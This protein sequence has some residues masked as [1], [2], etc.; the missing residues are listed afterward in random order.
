MFLQYLIQ[1]IRASCLNF[2]KTIEKY[3]KKQQIIVQL[4]I[5]RTIREYVCVTCMLVSCAVDSLNIQ[6]LILHN[7]NFT[8]FIGPVLWIMKS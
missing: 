6:I 4:I 3:H 5:E 8:F 7:L 2:L 1:N